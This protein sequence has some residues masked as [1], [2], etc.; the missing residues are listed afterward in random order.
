MDDMPC[1]NLNIGVFKNMN[2]SLMIRS[3]KQ[4]MISAINQTQTFSLARDILRNRV[5]FAAQ[6]TDSNFMV[7]F[8]DCDLAKIA[9]VCEPLNTTKF[10]FIGTVASIKSEVSRRLMKLGKFS[11]TVNWF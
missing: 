2:L 6:P 7:L 3:Y 11:D 10:E 5:E 1:K 9:I 8:I 4:T